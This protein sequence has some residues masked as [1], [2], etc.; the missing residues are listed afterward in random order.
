V[1]VVI[2]EATEG[3]KAATQAQIEKAAFDTLTIL[4][5][6][7][8]QAAG[9]DL[10]VTL[11]GPR[12]VEGRGVA[13]V[14][15]GQIAEKAL[16][17]AH[18]NGI[19]AL[20]VTATADPGEGIKDIRALGAVIPRLPKLEI[21]VQLDLAIQFDGLVPGV[22]AKLAGGSAAYLAVE[23]QLLALGKAAAAVAGS[24][25]LTIRPET[26]IDPDGSEFEQVRKALVDLDPGELNIKAEL[27]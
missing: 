15:M 5:P 21:E 18:S 25:S 9:I 7:Q 10:G 20:H 6:A 2:G 26:P 11:K 27:A 8:S 17:V 22:T 1:V 24:M 19:A 14:A 16:D 23:D 12:P 4:T 3:T 13:G